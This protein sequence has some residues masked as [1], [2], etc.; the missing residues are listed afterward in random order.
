MELSNPLFNLLR[1]PLNL[2]G[3][4]PMA[5]ITISDIRLAGFDLF[6]DS[7]SFLNELTNQEVGD[8][9]GGGW[10]LE[11]LWTGICATDF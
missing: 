2:G 11:L 4:F 1:N 8:V 5:N 9:L 7:E 6:Q 3:H 10:H